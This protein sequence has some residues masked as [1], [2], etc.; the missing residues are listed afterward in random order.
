LLK[1][2]PIYTVVSV[3]TETAVALS[4][5]TVV[6]VNAQGRVSLT[7]GVKKTTRRRL[8]Q[9]L[10]HLMP[11]S[12]WVSVYSLPTLDS[13]PTTGPK[14]YDP[15]LPHH[16][17]GVR[18]TVERKMGELWSTNKK[19]SLFYSDKYK[20]NS[21]HAACICRQM[22]LRSVHAKLLEAEFQ[23]NNCPSPNRTYGAGRTHVG[24]S[25]NFF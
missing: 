8:E 11:M 22:Q 18:K 5:M 19:V 20:V 25:P 12:A 17:D 13:R 3:Y 21:A 6:C 24:L 2:I 4:L 16:I 7:T 9:F 23:P 1:Y 14:L 15:Y 10:T